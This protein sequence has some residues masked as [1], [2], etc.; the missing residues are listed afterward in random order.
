MDKVTVGPCTL[1]ERDGEMVS[2]TRWW[3]EACAGT[4]RLVLVGG[5][6]G[7]G[8]TVL[9][10]E[11]GRILGDVRLLRGS[12]EP[13]TTPIAFGPLR[14][15]AHSL[16]PPLRQKLTGP[17]DPVEAR[18]LMLDELRG[19]AGP[20]L[21]VFE[22]AHWADEATLDLL[23]FLGRRIEACPAM[24]VVVYRQDEVGARHPLRV[25]AGD[26]AAL[27]V[28][29]RLTVPM[30]SE[31]AVAR[32]AEGTD[33]DPAELY[34]RTG[35][36]AFF[37]TQVLG[38]GRATVPPTVRDAVLARAARLEPG[39]REAL[40]ALACLGTRAAPWL[41]EAVSGRAADDLD[42]CVD[43]GLVAAD[44]GAVAF[45]HELVRVAVMEAIPPGRAAALHR[46]ALA[47]LGARPPGEV[48]P[49]R[50]ADHAERAD[51][52][53][54]VLAYAPPRGTTGIHAGGSHGGRGTP[55]PRTRSVPGQPGRGPGRPPG[56]TRPAV[57]SR[58]RPR[59]RPARPAG[60]RRGVAGGRRRPSA[61]RGAGR[62]GDHRGAP[63]PGDPAR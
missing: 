27:P 23:R 15:M 28:V 61:G 33:I 9:V 7:A 62:A 59:R 3:R 21:V 18:H 25:L 39:A 31:A 24:L 12:S 53:A 5:D 14:D 46:R 19:G 43:R 32:L 45:R 22:D 20:T 50:L 63:G 1:E 49:A 52:R 60:G 38:D 4:G 56:G 10:E 11:F 13:L 47:V 41:V 26:L 57:S 40:D 8:K 54:A 2:L 36:N 42:A 34:R 48:E 51:D 37:V 55:P 16:S 29:R 44:D 6:A 30:L 35:G 58:R 17:A